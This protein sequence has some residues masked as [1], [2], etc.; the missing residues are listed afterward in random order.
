MRVGGPRRRWQDIEGL[1]QRTPRRAPVVLTPYPIRN[2]FVPVVEVVSPWR[3]RW[4]HW[5]TA[6]TTP[7]DLSLRPV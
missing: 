2:G 1:E 6:S 4:D 7:A 5:A 3:G